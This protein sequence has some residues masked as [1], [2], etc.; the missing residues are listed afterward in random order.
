MTLA[1]LNQ[2]LE[3]REKLEKAQEMLVALR[4]AAHPGASV[5]TGMPHTPGVKDKVGDLAAE[6][7]DMSSRID[8]L[9]A[10]LAAQE[11][12]ITAFIAEIEDDQTRMALRLRFLRGLSWKEVSGI[13]GRYTSESSIKSACYRYFREQGEEDCGC[14]E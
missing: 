7:A 4:D 12:Q 2:H 1:E 6:I 11:P 13:L 8:Y 10:E 9:G 14:D 5:I 3:L